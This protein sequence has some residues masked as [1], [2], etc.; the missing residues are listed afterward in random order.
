[1]DSII[2]RGQATDISPNQRSGQAFGNDTPINI[3]ADTA[4]YKGGITVL[5][6]NVDV[7]QGKNR[8][9]SNEMDIFREEAKEDASGSLKLGPIRRID[10]KGNFRYTTP[11][12]RVTGDRGVYER[13][14]EIMTVTGK[15]KVCLLYTSP[16]P[17]DKRQ[18]R[19]PS[20]A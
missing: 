9:Q 8:T 3:T 16:S 14:E 15:V 19:M 12:H 10:A 11:E 4:S 17:R 5:T 2:E 13:A 20:S 18:S 6:G 7:K 1:M